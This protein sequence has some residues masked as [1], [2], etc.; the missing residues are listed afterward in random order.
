MNQ[1]KKRYKKLNK[2][3]KSYNFCYGKF[4]RMITKWEARVEKTFWLSPYWKNKQ[5]DSAP[6]P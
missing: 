2:D 1:C 5:F 6:S 3:I 4:E